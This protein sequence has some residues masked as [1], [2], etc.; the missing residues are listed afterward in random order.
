LTRQDQWDLVGRT[1]RGE[2]MTS[3]GARGGNATTILHE[4]LQSNLPAPDKTQARLTDEAQIVVAAGVETTAFALSVGTFHIVNTPRIYQKLHSELVAA[5]P[6]AT[7]PSPIFLSSNTAVSEGLYPRIV[8]LVVRPLRPESPTPSRQAPGVQRLD[9]PR[10]DYRR[11]DHC[12]CP[13][14]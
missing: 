7:K 5:F 8:A 1:I 4:I 3:K 6:T 12:G 14:R 2:D 9:D 10:R 11:H 13:P